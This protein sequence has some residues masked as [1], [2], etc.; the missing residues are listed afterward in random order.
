MGS[1]EVIS[2]DIAAFTKHGYCYVQL[3]TVKW[4]DNGYIERTGP[5]GCPEVEGTT[6][7]FLWEK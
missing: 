3:H 4:V 1:A 6:E 7:A 2:I 5:R